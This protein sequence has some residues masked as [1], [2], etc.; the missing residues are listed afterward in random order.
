MQ[1]TATGTAAFRSIPISHLTFVGSIYKRVR[2]SNVTDRTGYGDFP[3]TL[4]A[5]VPFAPG[6]PDTNVL[7]LTATDKPNWSEACSPEAVILSVPA[8]LVHPLAGFTNTYAAPR[9]CPRG[10]SGAPASTVLPLMDTE[11]PN[12]SR[13]CASAAVSSALKL[14]VDVQPPGG[15]TNR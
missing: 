9:P 13:M 8:L 14:D 6:T 2:L 12:S 7:P 5:P 1:S 11:T 3:K 10:H 15:S 4:A